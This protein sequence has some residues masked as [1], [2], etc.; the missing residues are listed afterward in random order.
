MSTTAAAH[1]QHHGPA[2]WPPD[3]QYGAAT[4][5]KIG[6]WVFLISDAFSFA[7]LLIAMGILRSGRPQWAQQGE[8]ALALGFTALLTFLLVS[9][10]LTNVLAWA[11]AVEGRRRATAALLAVTA[12]GGVLFL[13]GQYQE[14]FGLW[15][16][17]LIE[18]GLV[19]GRSARASTF[20]VITGYHGL[21]VLV[22]VLYIT[23]VLAQ[24]VRGRATAHHVELLGLYWCFVDFVWIFVFSFVY[25][26]P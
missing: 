2:A 25:L 15:G 21:H 18:E 11:A 3:A 13:V 22:G 7:G 1:A 8:P 14:W 6:M 19:F 12:L 23:T 10:S 4:P 26:M 20:Y 16:P 5:G 9:T 24:Y 17:G